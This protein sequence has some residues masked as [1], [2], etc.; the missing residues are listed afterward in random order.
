MYNIVVTSLTDGTTCNTKI[1]YKNTSIIITL[2]YIYFIKKNVRYSSDW[3]KKILCNKL[4]I[5]Y[6]YYNEIL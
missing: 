2:I 3:L 5:I 1:Q 6:K 4:K